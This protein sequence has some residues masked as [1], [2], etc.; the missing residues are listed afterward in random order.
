MRGRLNAFLST[1]GMSVSAFAFVACA[2]ST[3]SNS[4]RA[5]LPAPSPMVPPTSPPQVRNAENNCG[6]IKLP[7]QKRVLSYCYEDRAGQASGPHTRVD[8]LYY[9]HGLGGNV[10]EIFDPGGRIVLNGLEAMLRGNM[11][12]VVGLS[13]GTEG[14]IGDDAGEIVNEGL[15]QVED[16]VAHGKGVR[17]IAMGGSMGGHNTLRVA[18]EPSSHFMAAASLCP[19]IGSFNGYNKAEVDAY[20]ERHRDYMDRD[21]F[22]RALEIYKRQLTSPEDWD[23]NNPFTFLAKGAYDGLPIFLS[24]GREDTLGFVEGAREFKKRS[25]ARSGMQVTYQE[26][27]GPH[28]TFDVPGLMRFLF[29]QINRP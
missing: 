19:A 22:L 5:D 21:F 10:H 4:A 6:D 7:S 18:A 16:I 15:S 2:G 13:L 28:C 27:R 29:D 26:V 9:F 20:M 8:V 23:A 14:V 17:R 25:D 12:I 1:L 3:S 11:P 24:V